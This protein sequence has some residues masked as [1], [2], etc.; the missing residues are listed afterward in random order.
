MERGN[1]WVS[2]RGRQ[3]LAEAFW[4]ETSD[5]VTSGTLSHGPEGYTLTYAEDGRSGLGRTQ[6]TLLFGGERVMMM[7]T[8][9][10]NTHMIFEK[11]R[12]H[13]SYYDTGM[14]ALTVGVSTSKLSFDVGG[15][16]GPIDL[17]MEYTLDIDNEVTGA[18]VVS[19]RISGRGP[20]GRPID[21]PPP[22][23]VLRGMD[24][25]ILN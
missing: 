17:E 22:G 12:K 23:T 15:A 20:D 7:H 16:D 1:V 25:T 13:V 10:V 5:V 4:E 14:G 19:I 24:G 9:E 11:D 21:A 3:L 18:N 8:G 2:I 6:T